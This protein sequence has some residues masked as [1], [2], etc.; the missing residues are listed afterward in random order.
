MAAP[1]ICPLPSGAVSGASLSECVHLRGWGSWGVGFGI[2]T[3]NGAQKRQGWGM[4]WNFRGT[5]DPDLCP[6]TSGTPGVLEFPDL[7]EAL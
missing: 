5:S 1:G 3:L 4:T 7:P 6:Q 2:A